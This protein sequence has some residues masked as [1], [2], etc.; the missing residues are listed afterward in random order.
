MKRAL[1]FLSCV[2]GL[3]IK[4]LAEISV[5]RWFIVKKKPMIFSRALVKNKGKNS[6]R[7]EFGKALCYYEYTVETS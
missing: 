1:L 4:R 5:R 7:L 2:K 3:N 6:V